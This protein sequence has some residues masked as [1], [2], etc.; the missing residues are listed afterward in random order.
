MYSKQLA[1]K[2][3]LSEKILKIIRFN[4]PQAALLCLQDVALWVFRVDNSLKKDNFLN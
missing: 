3:E 4:H 1:Y 2:F